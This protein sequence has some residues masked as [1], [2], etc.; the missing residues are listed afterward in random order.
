MELSAIEKS[1]ATIGIVQDGTLVYEHDGQQVTVTVDTPS[2]YTWLETA[3]AFTFVCEEGT[4]TA[5][6]VRAG[7]RRGGWYWRAY[8]RQHGR[9][10][11][12][13]LGVSANLTL[14][15]LHEAAGRLA[16][17]S[18]GTST[19]KNVSEQKQEQELESQT[20]TSSAVLPPILILNTKFALPCLP[21]QHVSRPHLLA[22]VEQGV[23]RP[24]TLVSAPAGS[25]K[26]TLLAE[27]AA[28]P[29]LPLVCLSL[30]TADN[31]PARFL[32]SLLAMLARLDERLGTAIQADR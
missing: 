2:W 21:V 8:R 26:T 15:C 32:S 20:M 18:E 3:T 23:Q 17:R 25:G 4:V 19:R 22:L 27:W 1:S 16:A 24:L 14:L 5:R 10:S 29:T 9:L 31:D 7:N 12:C 11:R 28:T 13:Y 30:E 6:K